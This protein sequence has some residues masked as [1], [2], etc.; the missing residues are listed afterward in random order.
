MLYVLKASRLSIAVF[1]FSII[2]FTL[3]TQARQIRLPKEELA[4]EYVLPVFKGERR[5]VVNRNIQLQYKLDLSGSAL[6]RSD[7]PFYYPASAMAELGFFFNEFHGLHLLGVYFGEGLSVTGQILANGVEDTQN[8][9]ITL[10]LNTEL[11]SH[12]FLAAFLSYTLTPFYGKFSLSKKL[13]PNFNFNFSFGLGAMFLAQK[14]CG[15]CR[16]SQREYTVARPALLL[17]LS[18]KI[19]MGRRFYIHTDISFFSYY[20]PNPLQEQLRRNKTQPLTKPLDI[21]E[22]TNA[23]LFD[24]SEHSKEVLLIRNLVGGGLGIIL[25]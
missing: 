23:T 24:F 3:Q 7:E 6:F 10:Q 19:F 5:T 8:Q 18:Q 9:E 11:V 4:R 25:F 13:V 16:E 1:Y 12:P 22:Q 20:G 17:K 2:F 15:S 14:H 21:S